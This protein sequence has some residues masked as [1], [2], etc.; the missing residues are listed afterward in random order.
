MRQTESRSLMP[1]LSNRVA[2]VTGAS[3]GIG[4]ATAIA[5]ASEGAHVIVSARTKTDLDKVVDEIR[6]A[7]GQATAVVGDASNEN[8]VK[9]V[10]DAAI[11]TRGTLDVLV[12]NAG[13]GILGAIDQ[14]SI[15]DFDVQFASNVRSVFLFTRAVVPI[16]KTNG[17]GNIVNVASIS[18]LKGFAGASVYAASKFATI[19][20]SRSLDIELREDQI[21]VT[22]ICPAGVDTEWAMGTGLTK[23]AV[24]DV[25]RLDPST[26]ADAVLY[27]LK[28]PANARVTELVVYPMS[29]TGHQ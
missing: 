19:G 15:Q 17:G 21:K 9:R 25:E 2:I 8:D 14:T 1:S 29:E 7:G 24:A 13:V 18:G 26:I 20:M 11:S 22:A 10:V 5:L 28:Q 16:L 27:V 12:N 3:R 4:R 6:E 23:E